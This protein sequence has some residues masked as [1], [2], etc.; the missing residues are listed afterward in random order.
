MHLRHVSQIRLNCIVNIIEHKVTW[1]A[2]TTIVKQ[3]LEVVIE[4]RSINEADILVETKFQ[5]EAGE[6]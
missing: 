1:W 6:D 4:V 3:N 5:F 2:C